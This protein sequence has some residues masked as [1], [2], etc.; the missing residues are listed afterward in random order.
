LTLV[1]WFYFALFFALFYHF[2]IVLFSP[3]PWNEILDSTKH[4]SSPVQDIKLMD[5]LTESLTLIA[6]QNP[7]T[8][9]EDCLYLS[10]YTSKPSETTNLPV[11]TLTHE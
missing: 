8:Y 5:G 9:N 3:E 1:F 4:S 7:K 2:I 11:S 10:V 6:D